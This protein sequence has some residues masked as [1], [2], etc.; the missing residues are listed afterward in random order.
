MPSLLTDV[1][2][3]LASFVISPEFDDSKI[4]RAAAAEALKSASAPGSLHLSAL[5]RLFGPQVIA[6]EPE[7]IW[8]SLAMDFKID[9]SETV[10][11]K[12]M[13]ASTLV[14]NPAFYWDVHV[15]E[16]TCLAFNAEPV[17]I[18]V[19]QESSPAQ[20]SWGVYEA[21]ILTRR[22][23]MD[24]EFDHDPAQYTAASLYRAGFVLAPE[25]LVFAQEELN[26]LYVD[27]NTG[28]DSTL[29]SISRQIKSIW[30]AT[31]KSKLD[32]LALTESP[33]DVQIG[34]LAAVHL[35]VEQQLRN[36]ADWLEK[37]QMKD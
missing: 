8:L 36:Y 30:T 31:D 23:G 32:E 22:N 28:K 35:Y 19:L 37:F 26:K 18:N 34:R 33:V 3:K 4:S 15:F 1:A 9:P 21:E 16:D 5:K 25:M 6:W 10:R 12:I 24:P 13:A 14:Q 27:H 11:N 7:S 29:L 17:I 2:V 20:L